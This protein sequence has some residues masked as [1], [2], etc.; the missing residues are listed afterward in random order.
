ML[1]KA[2]LFSFI[3]L[4]TLS[5]GCSSNEKTSSSE[6]SV[7]KKSVSNLFTLEAVENASPSIT[8]KRTQSGFQLKN[9]PKKILIFDIYATWCPPCRA[10]AVV[11]SNI[12]KKYKDDVYII[13]LSIE[14]EI[15]DEKLAAY[16]EQYHIDYT[17]ATSHN[18][19]AMVDAIAQQLKISQRFPIPLVVMYQNGKLLN[20]YTGATEEEFIESD[21]KQALGK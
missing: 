12:Q 18:T 8:I 14:Q 10:E 21:I 3:L 1:N 7:S 15:K 11:L 20:Y 4:S 13:G 19:K 16:K 5:S 6:K 9:D 2:I 17:L